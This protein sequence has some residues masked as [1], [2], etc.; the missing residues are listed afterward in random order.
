MAKA[1]D[2]R[3]AKREDRKPFSSP[4]DDEVIEILIPEGAESGKIPAGDQYI[5]KLLGVTQEISKTSGNPMLV[6]AFEMYEGEFAGMDF[7]M[8]TTL[9]DNAY[10]EA[11]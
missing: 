7:R 10:L 5:G 8:W 9:S 1:D 3:S 11:V 4:A 6:W 2:I